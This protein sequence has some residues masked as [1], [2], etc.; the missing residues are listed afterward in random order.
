MPELPGLDG[1]L[2][3]PVKFRVEL[4]L[5]GSRGIRLAP[6]GESNRVKLSSPWPDPSFQG[7]FLPTERT[8]TPE[9][10]TGLWEVSYYG[11]GYPQQ[12]T[13]REGAG[14]ARGVSLHGA[15]LGVDLISLLDV[16]R[17]VERSI[18]YGALFIALV[19]TAF[20]LFE[21]LARVRVHPFQYTLVGAALCLFYLALLSLSEFMAFGRAYLIGAAASTAA[22]AWYSA[23]AL[24]S[25]RRS[26]LL[27]AGI[28]L[29]YGFLYVILR[30]Q[31]YSLLLG[32]AGLFLVLVLVM[33]VTRRID[34][35]AR[36][37]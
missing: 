34:W 4:T 19:F 25:G 20:F 27:A 16:Y 32:T 8:V 35:Y 18:K 13:D 2:A 11:R 23:A 26:A 5:K 12:W 10:F 9:G 3:S 33:G 15:L 36:E 28:A 24:R 14:P 17:Y 7:A 22:I 31:D 29:T 6:V 21:A 37:E 1:P 30:L